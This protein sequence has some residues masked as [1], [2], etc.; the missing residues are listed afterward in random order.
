V[1]IDPHKLF[2]EIKCYF[3]GYIR[4]LKKDAHTP[5]LIELRQNFKKKFKQCFGIDIGE[6]KPSSS[7]KRGI[8][9]NCKRIMP[10]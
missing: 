5:E 7:N 1:V 2:D 10:T 4:D 3:Y 6:E 9:P 8:C